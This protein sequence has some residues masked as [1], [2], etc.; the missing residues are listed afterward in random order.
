MRKSVREVM[1]GGAKILGN[2]E[3]GV[4]AKISAGSIVLQSVPA[5][6]SGVM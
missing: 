6:I 1:I 3:V 4:G 2:I 5:Y